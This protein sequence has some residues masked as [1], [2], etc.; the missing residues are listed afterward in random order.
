MKQLKLGIEDLLSTSRRWRTCLTL[1]RNDFLSVHKRTVLGLL[2]HPLYVGVWIA[3]LV[4]IFK[5][6]LDEG[7][8]DYLGYVAIG[9]LLWSFASTVLTRGAAC[10]V[11]H[12]NLILN[13][14]LP[15]SMHI[16]RDL[17]AEIFRLFAQATV[18]VVFFNLVDIQLGPVMLLAAP[19]LVAGLIA[20]FSMM[21]ILAVFGVRFRDLHFALASLMRFLFFA[22]PVFW[23]PTGD[24]LRYYIAMVNPLT[25]FLE[26]VRA[27]LLG[28]PPSMVSWIIVASITITLIPLSV[29]SFASQKNTVAF[30]L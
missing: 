27:P 19:G 17:L 22:S 1:A 5:R 10:F 2:W 28:Y 16:A 9:V 29:W 12:K 18:L 24:G 21:V 20:A 14:N 15:L 7:T 26:I 23:A 13:M 11:R 4:I 30:R 3:G 6:H 8:G 25:H